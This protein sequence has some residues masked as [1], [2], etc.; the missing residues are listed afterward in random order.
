[1]CVRAASTRSRARCRAEIPGEASARSRV[2]RDS[3]D[4]PGQHAALRQRPVQVHE[5]I[6]VGGMPQ[7]AVRHLLGLGRSPIR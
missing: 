2:A 6:G 7:R 4:S 1:M 3:A 5:D